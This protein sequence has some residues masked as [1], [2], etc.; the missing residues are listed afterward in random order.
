MIMIQIYFKPTYRTGPFGPFDWPIGPIYRPTLDHIITCYNL[1]AH[2]R[3]LL[4][5]I[6]SRGKEIK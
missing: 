5:H 4:A 3:F 6:G 2:Y 1:S